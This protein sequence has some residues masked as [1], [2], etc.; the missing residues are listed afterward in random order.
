MTFER[1]VISFRGNAIASNANSGNINT[2]TSPTL[3]KGPSPIHYSPHIDSRKTAISS[4]VI[5]L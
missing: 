3:N 1:Q 2:D 4:Y 5:D